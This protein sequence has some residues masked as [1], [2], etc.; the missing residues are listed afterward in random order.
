MEGQ[1]CCWIHLLSSLR[2][3]ESV[4]FDTAKEQSGCGSW[5]GLTNSFEVAIEDCD[6]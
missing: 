4:L 1:V 3:K 2:L 5:L 6:L